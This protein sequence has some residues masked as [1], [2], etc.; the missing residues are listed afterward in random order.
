MPIKK[1]EESVVSFAETSHD[2][3][4]PEQLV[5]TEPEIEMYEEK[6]KSKIGRGRA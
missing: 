5:F 2:Q 1:L 6:R 3:R 4:D